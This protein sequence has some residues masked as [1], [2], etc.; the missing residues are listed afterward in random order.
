MWYICFDHVHG[1]EPFT[2][3]IDIYVR[4]YALLVV[5]AKN[6]DDDGLT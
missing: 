4:R 3:E 1:S 2:L 5:L 6:D